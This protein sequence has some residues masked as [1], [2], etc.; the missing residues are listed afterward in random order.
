M[1]TYL[2]YENRV[3]E[4][5][6][7][8]K[9]LYIECMNL[10]YTDFINET[11]QIEDGKSKSRF[12][13]IINSIKLLLE[14]I[15][16]WIKVRVSVF[17]KKCSDSI[18]RYVVKVVNAT[19]IETMEEHNCNIMIRSG[20]KELKIVVEDVRLLLSL[21]WLNMNNKDFD[22]ENI[23]K[24]SE[25][26]KN[27]IDALKAEN[28]KKEWMTLKLLEYKKITKDV[29][30]F[31]KKS[32]KLANETMKFIDKQQSMIKTLENKDSLSEDELLKLKQLRVLVIGNQKILSDLVK[33]YSATAEVF[34][35][36]KLVKND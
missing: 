13:K 24:Y 5:E 23:D 6:L 25:N 7:E 12:K 20:Y 27:H 17:F 10:E 31:M 30:E 1:N 29:I 18:I 36:A 14:K 3:L 26:L 21:Q 9:D 33:S 22:M 16:N 35:S 34:L 2:L 11:Q 4:E 32:S 8:L 28:N 15:Y 19:A